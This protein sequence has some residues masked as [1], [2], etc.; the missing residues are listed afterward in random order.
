MHTGPLTHERARELAVAALDFDL[1]PDE[2]RR[3]DDHLAGCDACSRFAAATRRDQARLAALPQREAPPHIHEALR[4]AED[5]RRDRTRPLLVL[6]AAGMAG[7]LA[8]ATLGGGT[9]PEPVVTPIAASQTAPVA[10]ATAS[11]A[12]PSA[13]PAA[14]ARPSRPPSP[15]P[16][17]TPAD[18]LAWTQVPSQPSF[19]GPYGDMEAVVATGDRL[20]AV[21]DACG[22]TLP[23]CHVAIWT[24]EDGQA[25][26]RVPDGRQ[27][28]AGTWTPLRQGELTDVIA[29]RDG[30]VAV[31]RSRNDGG[32]QAAVYRSDDGLHWRRSR[33]EA[34]FQQGTMEGITETP[35]GFV[36]VGNMLK[37][38]E[39]HASAWTSPDGLAWVRTTGDGAAFDV[40]GVGTLLD[41]R[42]HGG[43]I[44]VVWTGSR[45][46]AIGNVCDPA[47]GSCRGVAWTSGDGRSWTRE[48]DELA[49]NP[50][51]LTVRDGRLV[52]VG[53][54][55]AGRARSWISDDNGSTWRS[56]RPLPAPFGCFDA[57]VGTP[58][59]L[60]ASIATPDLTTAVAVSSDGRSWQVVADPAT[61]GAGVI[62]G[63]GWDPVRGQVVGVGWDGR[64]PTAAVWLGR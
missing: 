38:T 23:D 59:G 16:T 22:P 33:D 4:K 41:G 5:K 18:L 57:V 1:S 2:W 47:G 51:S 29:T 21:G 27:F 64:T 45:V 39:A 34:S 11:A 3:L 6:A 17:I 63:L 31:G 26:T 19:A 46:V 60:V 44:D 40:G 58:G 62:N 50:Y 49:G 25:W 7:A 30:L 54:D 56:G 32:R 10:L 43:M 37:D 55:G 9:R 14:S 15:T 53:D 36:A 20:V 42:A 35:D 24:S 8:F 48:A 13:T 61:L 28:D 12:E 52:A